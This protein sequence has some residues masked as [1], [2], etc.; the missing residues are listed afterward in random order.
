MNLFNPLQMR[1]AGRKNVL[2]TSENY[3][4]PVAILFCHRIEQLHNLIIF[5]PS[6]IF[7]TYL[8][9][10]LQLFDFI[11]L[12]TYSVF[13]GAD[14]FFYEIA[15]LLESPFYRPRCSIQG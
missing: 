7:N 5:F 4:V 13:A 2:G 15:Q 3:S 12:L 1:N 11:F 10:A 6:L 8:E 14:V 9:G